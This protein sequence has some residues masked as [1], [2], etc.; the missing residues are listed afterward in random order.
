MGKKSSWPTTKPGSETNKVSEGE[1][2]TAGNRRSGCN[3]LWKY[4][5]PSHR[6]PKMQTCVWLDT[7]KTQIWWLIQHIFHF[8]GFF[9]CYGDKC[10]VKLQVC[11]LYSEGASEKGARQSQRSERRWGHR[12][13]QNG[14]R[15]H[16][17]SPEEPP[18]D[19]PF[20]TAAK[21]PDLRCHLRQNNRSQMCTAISCHMH[22]NKDAMWSSKFIFKR[23]SEVWQLLTISSALL[24][25]LLPLFSHV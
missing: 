24:L 14:P 10:G 18:H 11:K 22:E 8:V 2:E 1:I 4:T 9:C 15:N 13:G 19:F 25:L 3:T 20:M 23:I 7:S 17:V 5:S 16:Q 21:P 6:L 12:T